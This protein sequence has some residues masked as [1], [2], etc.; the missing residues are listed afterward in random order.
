MSKNL[1]QTFNM[2]SIQLITSAFFILRFEFEKDATGLHYTQDTV[3]NLTFVE[4]RT[5]NSRINQ[6]QL[7]MNLRKMKSEHRIVMDPFS[8]IRNYTYS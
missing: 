3:A 8:N 6:Q 2:N 1:F 7:N 5:N 4:C